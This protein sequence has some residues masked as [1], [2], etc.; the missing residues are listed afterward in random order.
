MRIMMKYTTL[1][2]AM[3][4]VA[5]NSASA[6][7]T[8]PRWQAWLGCW[9]SAAP[10]DSYGSAQFAPPVVC[11]VPTASS[12]VV[13]VATIADGK[14]VKRDSIDASGRDRALQAKGCE[15]TQVARWSADER[16]VYLKS[17]SSCEGMRTSGSAILA[18][19]Q[20][21]E[22][23]DVR[24]VSAGEGENVRVARYHDIGLPT[25]IPAEIASAL[26]GRAMASQAA[27]IAAGAT[28]GT[29][30]VK[31]ATSSAS[32]GVVEAWIMERAQRFALGANELVALADAG[33]PAR[34]TDAMVAVS[35]PNAFQVAR[36]DDRSVRD[37]E[38]VRYGRT[39]PVYLDPY[40]SPW[41]WGYSRYGNT[42]YGYNGYGYGGYGYGGYGSGYYGGAPIIIVTG[43]QTPGGGSNGQ[44]VKGRGYTQGTSGG[45]T[46]GRDYA[47]SNS[48]ASSGSS[49]SGSSTGTSSSTAP[50]PQASQPAEQR[51]AKPRP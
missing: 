8:G 7:G 30:A 4:L 14:V 39:I 18:M 48:G 12:D 46:G 16:R 19:T 26:R 33:I 40:Y 23:I 17:A 24:G 1:A 45:S 27:R 42:G 51:T 29:S 32:A 9:S 2:L 49:S 50:A 10:G 36:A 6:Q 47:P 31:E 20:A 38:D 35:Y 11:I 43:T 22:W 15:G 37:A 28:I 34:V 3:G 13:E 21:G 41:G 5:V 25:A 44:M